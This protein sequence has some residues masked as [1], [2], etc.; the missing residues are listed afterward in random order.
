VSSNGTDFN[1]DYQVREQ[2]TQMPY[3]ITWEEALNLGVAHFLPVPLPIKEHLVPSS[4]IVGIVLPI[5]GKGPARMIRVRPSS[6]ATLVP[7]KNSIWLVNH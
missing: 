4:Q 2:R 7:T 1:H 3:P 6:V 5:P